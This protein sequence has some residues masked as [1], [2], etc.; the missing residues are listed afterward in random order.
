MILVA[1]ALALAA[2]AADR[3]ADIAALR[4]AKLTAWPAYYRNNDAEGLA[5]FL[6]DGFVAFSDD[7]S[8]ESKAEVVSWVR[9]NK[10]ANAN[11]EFR[12]TIRDIAF[13]GP[14]IANIYGIGS[15]NGKDCRMQYTSANLFVRDDGRWK[16]KFSHTSRAACVP[17]EKS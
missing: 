6:A 17:K 4:Q 12:Y 7:G 14:D 10:W 11:N 15:F 1:M 13:Y 5:A 8:Q 16:P 3:A 2:P 9:A